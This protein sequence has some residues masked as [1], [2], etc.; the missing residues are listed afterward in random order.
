MRL[1]VTGVI[2]LSTCPGPVFAQ[3]IADR[4]SLAPVLSHLDPRRGERALACD[5]E[6]VKPSL[7]FG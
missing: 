3:A 7:S 6:P 1:W 2:F 4:A 5:V